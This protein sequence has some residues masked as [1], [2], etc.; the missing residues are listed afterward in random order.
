MFDTTLSKYDLF[1]FLIIFVKIIFVISAIANRYLSK[2]TS[3]STWL[4]NTQNIKVKT[5]FIFIALMSI[6]LIYLF[7]PLT[8]SKPKITTET[9]YLLYLFGWIILFTADW[10]AFFTE[11]KLYKTVKKQWM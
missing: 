7:N 11:S 1:I 6:L 9:S 3:S 2:K 4:E 8:K 10:G 5:E